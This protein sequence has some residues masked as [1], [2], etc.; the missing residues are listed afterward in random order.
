[1]IIA[2]LT[3]RS[4]IFF[5]VPT[6]F[7][8]VMLLNPFSYIAWVYQDALF[9]GRIAHPWAWLAFIILNL[10]F[11]SLGFLLFRILRSSFGDVL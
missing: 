11:L 10:G 4:N 7:F 6:A 2:I 3:D 9:Y 8:I 5:S 1:M